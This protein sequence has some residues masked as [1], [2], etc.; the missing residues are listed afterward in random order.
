MSVNNAQQRKAP[1]EGIEL[2]ASLAHAI[3]NPVSA[4][5]ELLFLM[6]PEAEFTP[7]GR[8]YFKLAHQELHRL[9]QI[10]HGA[11]DE[12]RATLISQ[13]TDI[14]ALLRTVVQFYES[15][16][17]AHGVSIHPSYSASENLRVHR[18][19]VRQMFS[20]V[21]LNAADALP[22][23]G[24][25]YVRI[26]KAH[27]WCGMKRR[28]LRVTFADNGRGILAENL[29]KVTDAFFTTKGSAGT[30][31]GLSL[32]KDTVKEHEGVLRVRSSTRL[33][34]SGTVFTIFLPTA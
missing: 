16:F 11:M 29:P 7:K 18:G 4:L 10:A 2:V 1:A 32:V 13:N 14:S 9:S 20:N 25:I 19:S 24:K 33:G 26:R 27:E 31:L 6:E 23:G 28:G 12:A 17:A 34:R 15:R 21:L 30:G 3:N 5:F 22:E 8:E